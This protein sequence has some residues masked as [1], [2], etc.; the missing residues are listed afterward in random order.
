M[1]LKTILCL[2]VISCLSNAQALYAQCAGPDSII[3]AII[4]A[5]NATFKW[6]Q[7]EST[8]YTL[9]I[10]VEG[11]TQGTGTRL[12]TA[13]TILSI[14]G[15]P[16]KT[17]YDVFLYSTC[18]NGMKDTTQI[19]VETLHF[20]DIGMTFLDAPTTGCDLTS[21]ED[22]SVQITNFGQNPQQPVLSVLIVR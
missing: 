21:A 2:F 8:A 22:I 6:D 3:V 12:N 17:R 11:F 19:K 9:E 10:G 18:G 5:D 15:I 14:N 13:D 4:Q 20:D 1:Q 16:Q 7:S